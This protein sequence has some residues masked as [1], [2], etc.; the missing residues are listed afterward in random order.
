MQANVNSTYTIDVRN[1]NKEFSGKK[2]V[3]D[4]NL[5][6]ERGEIFGFLGPNGSGK[7]T[8]IRMICGL[9][10]PD[11]GSGTCLGYDI[12]SQAEQIKNKI[13]YMTQRFSLYEDLTVYENLDFVARL[14]RMDKRRERVEAVIDRLEI[15]KQRQ[16]QLAGNLSGG[17]KQRLALGAAIIHEPQLL[18]LDEPTAGVDPK[19]RR[20]FWDEIYK[21]SN[22]GTTSL[23]TTHYMDEA[24]RCHRLAYLAYGQLLASGHI[25]AVIKNAKIR[26]WQISGPYL[27]KLESQLLHVPEVV[28]IAPFGRA[29]HISI[30]QDTPES[31]LFPYQTSDFN[32][33]E[34]PPSLEDAFIAYVALQQ[35]NFA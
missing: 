19:A 22:E 11:S 15:G 3:N 29:L 12:F 14:Y 20:E 6:V 23:I 5:Q 33:Q 7:T 27:N 16:Y 32:W 28:Q 9:L 17:W 18:L 13:G 35:D 24:E 26:T 1:I 31:T 25:D 8:T 34:I 21:L 2:V 30:R 4:V 10:T